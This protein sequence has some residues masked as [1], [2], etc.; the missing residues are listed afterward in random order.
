[1]RTYSWN[2][3]WFKTVKGTPLEKYNWDEIAEVLISEGYIIPLPQAS[4]ES[5]TRY[6]LNHDKLNCSK[7]EVHSRILNLLAKTLP[8]KFG[9]RS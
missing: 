2:N 4:G 1:M 9:V 6:I 3:L 5:T 7:F 8:A